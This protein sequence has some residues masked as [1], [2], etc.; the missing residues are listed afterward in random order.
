[1]N[2]TDVL[3]LQ[4]SFF[5]SNQTKDILFRKENLLKLKNSILK[6]Q[7]E[8]YAALKSDLNKSEYEA[9]LTEVSVVISEIDVAIKNIKKWCTPIKKSTPFSLFP[10][11]SYILS[12]PYGIA[13]ILSPWNYPF[14]LAIAPLV[15]AISAGNCAVIK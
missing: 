11:K 4:K 1:M 8:I 9:F 13:L 14:Q 2:I 3:K 5:D 12:E 6:N 10:S 7:K 15:A